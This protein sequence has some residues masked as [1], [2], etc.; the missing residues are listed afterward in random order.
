MGSS[1]SK[2]DNLGKESKQENIPATNVSGD[3]NSSVPKFRDQPNYYAKKL[4]FHSTFSYSA[5]NTTSVLQQQATDGAN[6]MTDKPHK[7]RR[8]HGRRP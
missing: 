3:G 2:P 7:T 8:P 1:V 5:M 6:S 4:S